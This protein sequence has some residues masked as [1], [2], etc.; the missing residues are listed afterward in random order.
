MFVLEDGIKQ[1]VTVSGEIIEPFIVDRTQPL[2]YVVNYQ[3]ESGS[4]YAT[5]PHL[6]DYEVDIYHG[7]LDTRTGRVV[8]PVIYD[9]VEMVQKV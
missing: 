2:R 3:P 8:I 7:V 6:V 5:H 9:S 1:L 4:E